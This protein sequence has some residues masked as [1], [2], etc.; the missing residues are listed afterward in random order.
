MGRGPQR[1]RTANPSGLRRSA[2]DAV[3]ASF[4]GGRLG[5]VPRARCGGGRPD[6]RAESPGA[7]RSAVRDIQGNGRDRARRQCTQSWAPRLHREP[8][9]RRSSWTGPLLVAAAARPSP[10]RRRGS[11]WNARASS[12]PRAAG[13][14]RPARWRVASAR[15]GA[16]NVRRRGS[17]SSP[18]GGGARG[19]ERRG[20]AR[21]RGGSLG[22]P[23]SLRATARRAKS[24]AVRPEGLFPVTVRPPG[25]QIG[26]RPPSKGGSA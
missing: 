1:R 12:I 14:P 4:Q 26:T 11:A 21:G 6:P 24:S 18:P 20:G 17:G 16:S 5:N 15:A 9:P 2:L 13:K 23:R 3:L 25:T 8:A 22:S 10:R 19:R 7:I